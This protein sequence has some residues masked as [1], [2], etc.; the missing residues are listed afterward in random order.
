MDLPYDLNRERAV[1]KRLRG[2]RR[3]RL[4]I[5]AGAIALAAGAA[6]G[7]TLTQDPPQLGDAWAAVAPEAPAPAPALATSTSTPVKLATPES[8][9]NKRQERVATTGPDGQPDHS[10]RPAIA[11][12]GGVEA[13]HDGVRRISLTPSR[14]AEGNSLPPAAS[15]F[16]PAETTATEMTMPLAPV[17]QPRP[18]RAR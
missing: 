13:P 9:P 5:V 12:Q 17:P 18:S 3:R 16:A 8:D 15:G 10:G 14:I 1:A 11:L 4:G 6:A 7:F 2:G